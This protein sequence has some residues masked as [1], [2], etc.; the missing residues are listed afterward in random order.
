M[1]KASSRHSS[2]ERISEA[3]LVMSA[4]PDW[5][6]FNLCPSTL[7]SSSTVMTSPTGTSSFLE[8]GW[9][10]MFSADR[11]GIPRIIL[12]L[13]SGVTRNSCDF[14]LSHPFDGILTL[15]AIDHVA[16]IGLGVHAWRSI[17]GRQVCM[18]RFLFCTDLVSM[19]L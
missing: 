13:A 3:E 9:I 8:A 1:S 16:R 18:R 5:P 4:A 19:R 12:F 10:V 14:V 6:K 15:E 11:K 2:A 17:T 7:Q